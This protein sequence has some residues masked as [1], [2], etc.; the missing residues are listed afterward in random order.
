MKNVQNLIKKQQVKDQMPS[1]PSQTT[2]NM[3]KKYLANTGRCTQGTNQSTMGSTYNDSQM[4]CHQHAEG[5]Y[6][7]CSLT[8]RHDPKERPP[9]KLEAI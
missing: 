1:Y 8:T 4:H 5:A 3:Q 9:Y 6:G 7:K 2:S